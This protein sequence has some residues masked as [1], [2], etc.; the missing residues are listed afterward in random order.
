MSL[1]FVCPELTDTT[2]SLAM[3]NFHPFVLSPAIEILV[4]HSLGKK[5][6]PT[7][8]ELK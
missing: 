3:P 1:P 8:E 5:V 2:Q 7:N 4:G 6:F